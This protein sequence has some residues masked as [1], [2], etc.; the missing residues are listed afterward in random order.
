VEYTWVY[1]IWALLLL[2]AVL[3]GWATSF[4]TLPGNW[5][6]LVLAAV[7]T[8]VFPEDATGTGL[9]WSMVG[10]L[11]GLAVL[12]EIVEFAAGAVGAARQGASRRAVALAL[13]GAIV[14]SIAGVAAGLPI[15]LFGSA[16]AALLG[17]SVGAF[18]GAYAGEVWKG[19]TSDES[20]AAGTSAFIGRLLGTVGKVVVGVVMVVVLAWDLFF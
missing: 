5:I 10:I 2:A 8:L 7:F 11:L 9:R 1:Y 4:L 16:I 20:M 18:I 17:G 14:G 19:R 15:P 12:G 13:L 3:V 6:V